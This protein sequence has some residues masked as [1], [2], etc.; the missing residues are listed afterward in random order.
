MGMNKR[1]QAEM[2][3]LKQ[4]LREAKALR[5]T[6]D[7]PPD[8]LPP[9][10]EDVERLRSGWWFNAYGCTVDQGCTSQSFH[11]LRSTDK[12][13]SQRPKSLYSS[14]LLALRGLR[15][16]KEIEFSQT[17]AKIDELIESQKGG[18]P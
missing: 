1:E 18:T 16:A 9:R 7:C 4:Q 15:R 3:S 6:E 17:L 5:F 11:S 2:D 13:D 12:T 10:S 8:V 14:R